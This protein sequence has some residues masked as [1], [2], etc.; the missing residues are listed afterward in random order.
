MSWVVQR[1]SM[2]LASFKGLIKDT[3]YFYPAVQA[4]RATR[5]LQ[6][7]DKGKGKKM[8][9]PEV[10]E[11]SQWHLCPVEELS[12]K[13]PFS[14]CILYLIGHNC[15]KMIEPVCWDIRCF[16]CTYCFL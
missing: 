13:L 12:R 11:M 7:V 10:K 4:S 15:A 8:K 1:W 9:W 5:W 6:V 2:G 14:D 3:G 16:A